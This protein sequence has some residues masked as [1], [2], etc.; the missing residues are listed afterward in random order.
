[1][2]A[3]LS[4]SDDGS[5]LA[6]VQQIE[7]PAGAAMP[8]YQALAPCR[9]RLYTVAG[10]LGILAYK[11]DPGDSGRF[12][13]GDPVGYPTAPQAERKAIEGQPEDSAPGGAGPCHLCFDRT[14]EILV[15]AN[16]EDGSVAVMIVDDQA[17]GALRPPALACHGPAGAEAGTPGSR[18]DVAHPHGVFIDP[19]NEWLISVDLGTNCL[20]TYRFDPE[21]IKTPKTCFSAVGGFGTRLHEGAGPRHISFAPSGRAFFCVNGTSTLP[22]SVF[23][24]RQF[25]P[26]H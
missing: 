15:C 23:C 6:P 13:E 18:Q 4:L 24:I 11:V 22:S 20:H 5:Q 19:S 21:V 3:V 10:P 9:S 2:L 16:Y 8:M 26:R 17:T 12:V 1:M 14:G 7:L 25:F